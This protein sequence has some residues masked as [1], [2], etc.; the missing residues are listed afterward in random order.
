[1]ADEMLDYLVRAEREA[2]ERYER[3]V[4]P[5]SPISDYN[6]IEAAHQI[7]GETREALERYRRDH[8]RT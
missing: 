8:L 6:A 3:L 5:Q 2:C 4:A 7:C 1:M